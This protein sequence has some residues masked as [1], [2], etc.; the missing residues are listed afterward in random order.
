[1]QDVVF[2]SSHFAVGN[3]KLQNTGQL[4]NDGFMVFKYYVLLVVCC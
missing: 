3:C 4:N 1:M 2:L